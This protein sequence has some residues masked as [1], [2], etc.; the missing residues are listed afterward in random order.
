MAESMDGQLLA[1][2]ENHKDNA[3]QMYGSIVKS[4]KSTVK[5]KAVNS[6]DAGM[7]SCPFCFTV[8]GWQ[9]G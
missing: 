1:Y 7:P 2:G 4:W 5:T 8:L 6:R 9:Y 3:L